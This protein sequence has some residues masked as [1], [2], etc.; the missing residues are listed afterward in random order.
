MA[1]ASMEVFALRP[2]KPFVGLTVC[3]V[4][5]IV[6]ADWLP[7]RTLA[8]LLILGAVAIVA[9]L[10]P[11]RAL[12]WAVA[13]LTFALLHTARHVDNSARHFAASLTEPRP[14]AVEGVVWSEPAVF[15]ADRGSAGATF[16][17]KLEGCEPAAPIAGR[18]CLARWV[19]GAPAYG[20]RV[21]IRGSAR[22]IEEARNPGQ[23]DVGEWLSRQGVFFEVKA[24]GPRDCEIVGH[25]G[26]NPLRRFGMRGRAWIKE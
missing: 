12:A 5:G 18:L 20:A 19:G 22:P 25:D 9:L 23:F 15:S 4:A 21:R 24:N 11:A 17:L 3:A 2:R 13:F 8:L 1:R 10:R 14:F 26:G 7:L 16:W 6:A